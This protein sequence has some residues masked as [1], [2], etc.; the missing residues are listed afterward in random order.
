[1]LEQGFW[2]RVRVRVRSKRVG[3]H[4]KSQYEGTGV[5]SWPWRLPGASSDLIGSVRAAA[6][7]P[8]TVD[9]QQQADLLEP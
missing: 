4:L 3:A 7:K 2:V 6:E 8:P 1:V 9:L 5:Y